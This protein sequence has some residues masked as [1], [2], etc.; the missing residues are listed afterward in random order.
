MVD[1]SREVGHSRVVAPRTRVRVATCKRTAV[2]YKGA[3]GHNRVAADK[4]TAKGHNRAVVDGGLPWLDGRFPW[5]ARRRTNIWC[6]HDRAL[7]R[8]R[9]AMLPG[10]SVAQRKLTESKKDRARWAQRA[11][12]LFLTMSVVVSP[13]SVLRPN[14]P[15]AAPIP[16]QLGSLL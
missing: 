4:R 15:L 16:R 1:R 3:V 11:A 12:F 10:G 13:R 2:A 14:A 7:S 9:S 5:V 6:P 8:S